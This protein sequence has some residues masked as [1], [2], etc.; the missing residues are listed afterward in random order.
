MHYKYKPRPHSA[1]DAECKLDLLSETTI[2]NDLLP[3]LVESTTAI[4]FVFL[5]LA[6]K[7]VMSLSD[8]ALFVEELVEWQD[9]PKETRTCL[10]VVVNV[11][12][13]IH[14][15]ASPGRFYFH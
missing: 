7:D 6:R 3:P 15:T 2:P 1:P 8:A 12:W 9:L 5:V 13:N 4:V 14:R 11:L 10:L